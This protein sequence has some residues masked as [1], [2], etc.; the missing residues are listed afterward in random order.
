MRKPTIGPWC[1]DFGS[2]SGPYIYIL[3]G[4]VPQDNAPVIGHVRAETKVGPSGEEALANAMLLAAAP[5]LLDALL[6][7]Q[8]AQAMPIYGD[9]SDF[10]FPK[11]SM[12]YEGKPDYGYICEKHGLGYGGGCVCCRDD[13]AQYQKQ[14]DSDARRARDEALRDAERKAAAAIEK[15]ASEGA[16]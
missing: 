8:A 16:K 14:K 7:Y 9:Y 6:A 11:Q 2:T 3:A 12:R 15:T 10:E 4:A 1:V 13:F 5:E